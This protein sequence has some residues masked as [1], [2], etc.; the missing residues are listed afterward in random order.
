M[1]KFKVGDKVVVIGT[2]NYIGNNGYFYTEG[3]VGSV[4]GL[5]E[6][7]EAGVV[8]Y[9]YFEDTGNWPEGAVKLSG[10]VW[11]G[12]ED[13]SLLSKNQNW[14]ETSEGIEWLSTQQD[15]EE[16][17]LKSQ[18]K[19][20]EKTYHI[21]QRFVVACEGIEWNCILAQVGSDVVCFID[22]E[23][24]NRINEPVSVVNSRKITEDEMKTIA[25]DC[26]FHL[27]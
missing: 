19:K 10:C 17:F 3:M 20:E 15:V 2:N 8:V 14:W 9:I 5:R 12:E 16:Q 1:A 25:G 22:L 13:L 21:G 26:T 24:G 27:L 4:E 23:S 18:E 6:D 7:K 11:A